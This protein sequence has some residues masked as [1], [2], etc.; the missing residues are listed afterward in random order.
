MRN[1]IHSSVT[2]YSLYIG[3]A[4][5]SINQANLRAINHLSSIKVTSAI[6]HF[7]VVVKSMFP[8]IIMFMS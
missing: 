2:N 8:K 7:G 3:S 4:E 5:E 6:N 1:S